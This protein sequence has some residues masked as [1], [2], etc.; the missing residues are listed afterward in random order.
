MKNKRIIVASLAIATICYGCS[1]SDNRQNENAA[2][3]EKEQASQ[4][5]VE[6]DGLND[7]EI[8]QPLQTKYFEVTIHS[9]KAMDNVDT[10]NQFADLKKED[11]I[12]YLVIDVAFKN[13]DNETR[14]MLE[15]YLEIMH[16]G[17]FYKYE[18]SELMLGAKGWG[19]VMERINPKMT[20]RTNLVYKIPADMKGKMFYHPSRSK[21]NDIVYL[22]AL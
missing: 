17:E 21:R 6:D 10:D 5:I 13:I 12:K 1:N 11:G 22:G 4:S 14:T 9:A 2:T 3:I 20:K 19:L 16:N 18:K 8:G 15:G 7:V